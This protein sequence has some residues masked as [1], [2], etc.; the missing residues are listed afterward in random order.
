VARAEERLRDA[1]DKLLSAQEAIVKARKD[2]AEE[3][4]RAAISEVQTRASSITSNTNTKLAVIDRQVAEGRQAIAEGHPFPATAITADEGIIR[5][6]KLLA[7][8]SMLVDGLIPQIIQLQARY[9]DPESEQSL[10]QTLQTIQQLGTTA[11]ES[12]TQIAQVPFADLERSAA[13]ILAVSEREQQG[14]RNQRALGNIESDLEMERQMLAIRLKTSDSLDLLKAK[15]V[16]LA[17]VQKDPAVKESIDS[18]LLSVQTYSAEAVKASNELSR[19]DEMATVSRARTLGDEVVRSGADQQTRIDREVATGNLSELAAARESL[20]IKEYTAEVAK[21]QLATAIALRETLTD[22]A[23]I[24]AANEYIGSLETIVAEAEAAAYAHQKAAYEAS[25]LGQVAKG[26]TESIGTGLQDLAR[27]ALNGFKDFNSI[28]DGIL[29]KIADIGFDALI[30]GIGGG[31]KSGSGLLGLVGSVFGLAHGTKSVP[32]YARGN[33][34]V[35]E[36]LRRERAISGKRPYLAVLHENEA[37][38]STLTGDAQLYQTM[39][40]DGRWNEIKRTENFARGT[41]MVSRSSSMSRGSGSN[42]VTVDRINSVDYVSVEQLNQILTIELPLA[43]QGGA[44][45][46][47]QKMRSPG[48]RARWGI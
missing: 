27:S 3:A 10:Q 29:N 13:R 7:E 33:S 23:A 1:D 25:M 24:D 48:Q 30:G 47:D 4:K 39:Q 8:Q 5:K 14:V 34:P 43:A 17:A 2:A 11:A 19:A 20:A 18:L 40:R 28:L 31:G 9:T 42:T 41:P 35:G 26:L 16:A 38:L 12:A 21:E 46:V 37:V 6:N 44:S 22:R 45:L 32:N 15:L 36:A